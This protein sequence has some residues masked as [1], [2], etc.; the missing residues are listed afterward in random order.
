MLVIFYTL[1]FS[2]W[3]IRFL[4]GMYTLP[5]MT[6]EGKPSQELSALVNNNAIYE[7]IFVKDFKGSDFL[8]WGERKILISTE[9]IFF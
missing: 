9:N 7:A 1:A 3:F 4:L 8:Q 6:A 5:L 2:Y